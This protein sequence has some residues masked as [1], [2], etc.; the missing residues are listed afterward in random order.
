MGLNMNDYEWLNERFE[1]ALRENHNM[2]DL[3]EEKNTVIA[4]WKAKEN[5]LKEVIAT[6][7]KKCTDLQKNNDR[8]RHEAELANTAKAPKVS[9]VKIMW[10]NGCYEE[11]AVKDVHQGD[12]MWTMTSAYCGRIVRVPFRAVRWLAVD[13]KGGQ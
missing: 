6:L 12:S 1:A 2:S 8:L 4:T 11:W 9:W 13:E 10:T 7:G 3:I 5:Q